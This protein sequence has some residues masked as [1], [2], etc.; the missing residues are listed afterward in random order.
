MDEARNAG[1]R[2]CLGDVGRTLHMNALE[3]AVAAAFGQEQP[4]VPNDSEK[5]RSLNRRVELA[6]VPRAGQS[7]AP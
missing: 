1:G 2:G 5:N 4:L 3:R 7:K 6:P